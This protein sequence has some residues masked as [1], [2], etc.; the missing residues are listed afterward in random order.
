MRLNI[1][2]TVGGG[3]INYIG[4]LDNKNIILIVGRDDFEKDDVLIQLLIESLYYKKYTIIW[5][6]HIG[7]S[8]ARLLSTKYKQ[9][10]PNKENKEFLKL[11]LQ[12]VR[13]KLTKSLI[14]LK[15]PRRWGFF[16][17]GYLKK[18]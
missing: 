7:V 12:K 18:V 15:Y 14:L 3:V 5:Y 8:T 2:Y 16:L 9:N 10:S 17:P 4:N 1:K 6:E 11:I 13:R